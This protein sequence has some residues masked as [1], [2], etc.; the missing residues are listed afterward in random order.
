MLQKVRRLIQ[1]HLT[2][3]ETRKATEG[4]NP[5]TL[6]PGSPVRQPI[7]MKDRCF[8]IRKERSSPIRKVLLSFLIFRTE[9]KLWIGRPAEGKLRMQA[10]LQDLIV[11]VLRKYPKLSYFQ[12]SSRGSNECS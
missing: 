5:S 11:G 4:A 7:Q 3:L 10:D 2:L 8:W 6:G 1:A 9:L 12:V